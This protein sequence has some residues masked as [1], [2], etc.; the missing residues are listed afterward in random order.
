MRHF[1]LSLCALTVGLSAYAQPP[2]NDNCSGAIPLT[3]GATCNLVTYNVTG[4]TQS[5]GPITCQ[6]YTGDSNDDVWFR[7]VAN[8][9]TQT[10][11]VVGSSGYDAVVDVNNGNCLTGINIACADATGAGGQESVTLNGLNMGSTYY[12]R[13]YDYGSGTPATTTLSICVTGA[14]GITNNDCSGFVLLTPTSAC[15]PTLGDVTGATMSVP[16]IDC[17]G[18][19]SDA[20]YDVWYGFTATNTEHI[21]T[22]EGSSGFDAVVDLRTTCSGASTIDCADATYDGGT[23]VIDAT[24]LTVGGNY[25]IR[26]YSFGSA[27]PPTTTFTICVQIPGG[28]NAPPNDD[29]VGATTLNMTANCTPLSGTVAGATASSAPPSCDAN[30]AND[31]VWYRFVATTTTGTVTVQ[32]IGDFD[33][34]MAVYQGASCNNLTFLGCVD[35]WGTNTESAVLTDLVVGQTYFVRV[36]D[37]GWD[38]VSSPAFTICLQAPPTNDDC[39]QAQTLT[40]GNGTCNPV[41]G[42]LASATPSNMNLTTCCNMD[43]IANDVWY[44]FTAP[45]P[46]VDADMIIGPDFAGSLQLFYSACSTNTVDGG[47]YYRQYDQAPLLAHMTNLTT[48]HTYFLRVVPCTNTPVP[49]SSA[50][51]T[52]CVHTPYPAPAND[53]CSTATALNSGSNCTYVNGTTHGATAS[54]ISGSL[55][56]LELGDD[57]DDDD[58]WYTVTTT[59]EALHVTVDGDG[60]STTGFDPVVEVYYTN[61]NQ[62][63]NLVACANNTG[64]GGTEQIDITS[65]VNVGDV[66]HVLVYDALRWPASTQ[67]FRI[68]SQ[69]SGVSTG[70]SGPA[71]EEHRWRAVLDPAARALVVRH[72]AAGQDQADW[73]LLDASGRAVAKG[74]M[75][76]PQGAASTIQLGPL[77]GGPYVLSLSTTEGRSVERFVLP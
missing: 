21:I 12:V 53:N 77:A 32:G 5:M 48:G 68:C 25:Y 1:L 13:V 30:A 52:I 43:N 55:C 59:S 31:D 20:A 64:P 73:V 45:G 6:G 10:V 60:N 75:R 33:P 36:F 37:A 34:M 19:H 46:T 7:F 62:Q 38:V 14:A 27:I 8:N 71:E 22:V 50:N 47:C 42:S 57:S 29:C 40:V 39:A 11:T 2:S 15:N 17:N 28:G 76:V 9:S 44:Q 69:G 4:A 51:F 72:E 23:E 41:Q 24:G 70:V 16:P 74:S 54:N 67:T 63:Y 3:V 66:F 65:G 58:V 61:C 26:V 49:A 56:W 18:A 35:E